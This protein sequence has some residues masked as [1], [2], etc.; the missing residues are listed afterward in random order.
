MEGSMRGEDEKASF[1]DARVDFPGFK[2][3]VFLR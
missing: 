1:S 3:D 2:S